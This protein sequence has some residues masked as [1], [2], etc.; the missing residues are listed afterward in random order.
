METS[1]LHKFVA[2]Y[3]IIYT[4]NPFSGLKTDNLPPIMNKT[5]EL[6]GDKK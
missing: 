4:S 6:Y 1:W 3:I 5:T 2:V